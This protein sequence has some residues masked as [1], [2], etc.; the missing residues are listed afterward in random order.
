MAAKKKP[1]ELG[2]K[3]PDM[4]RPA[5]FYKEPVPV[6]LYRL[7]FKGGGGGIGW[8]GEFDGED[9]EAFVAQGPRQDHVIDQ[10]LDRLP[11]GTTIAPRYEVR[12]VDE[13]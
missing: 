10:L 2:T 7:R 11:V 1:A 4:T 6:V 9:V 5:L 3:I 8:E 12:E 13:I